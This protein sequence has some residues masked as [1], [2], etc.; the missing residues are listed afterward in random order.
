MTSR[1]LPEIEIPDVFSISFS[2]DSVRFTLII[3]LS[4][5]FLL[6]LLS[7]KIASPII[8]ALTP[9]VICSLL[10]PK[11]FVCLPLAS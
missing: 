4:Q 11:V 5:I 2:K 1:V 9:E 6:I 10:N 3:E 7:I 8:V